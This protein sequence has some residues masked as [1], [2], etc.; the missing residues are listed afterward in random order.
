MAYVKPKNLSF[1]PADNDGAS[2]YCVWVLPTGTDVDYDTP[3][4]DVGMQTSGIELGDLTDGD[5]E[6][7]NYDIHVASKDDAGNMS[8]IVEIVSNYPLD[9]TAPLAPL[10]GSVS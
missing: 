9:L 3:F 8:D 4:Y 6:D 10:S 5:V 1:T 7:G 2:S